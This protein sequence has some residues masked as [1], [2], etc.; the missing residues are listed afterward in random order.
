MTTDFPV[1]ARVS[2]RITRVLPSGLLGVVEGGVRAM[3]RNRE[4]AWKRTRSPRDY[5]GEVHP[6]IVIGFNPAY[7]ELEVSL[8]F[9]ERDPWRE[10][11]EKYRPQTVVQ[12]RV[13]GLIETAAFVELEPGVEGFLPAGELP[14]KEAEDITE[15]LWVDDHVLAAVTDVD[16][17][18]RRIRLSVNTLLERRDAQFQRRIWAAARATE[19]A[20]TLGE[21]LPRDVRLR[22]LQVGYAPEPA[23]SSLSP[24]RV[25]VVED[26]EAYAAGLETWL[27]K[28]GCQVSLAPN[29]ETALDLIRMQS[30]GFHLV[31][32]DW[33]LPG[34]KG[35]E[36]VRQLQREGCPSRAVVIL[37]PAPLGERPEV[38]ENLR[39]TGVDVFSKS[40][41]EG[42]QTGLV[43][44]LD[45]L[46]RRGPRHR[47]LRRYWSVP[48]A[49]LLGSGGQRRPEQP[50]SQAQTHDATRAIL[51]R[52][53]AD[54]HA[55]TVAL[56]SLVPGRRRF[57]VECSV[58][59][60]IPLDG[61]PPDLIYSPLGTVVCERQEVAEAV[62]ADS[63]RF[64]RLLD[65]L[66][67]QGFL[68][69][70]L[71][72]TGG[73]ARGLILLKRVG[74]FRGAD[75]VQARLY[76]TLIA[77]VLQQE[78][79]LGSLKPWQ[80]QSA[81][82]QLVASAIHE[83]SNKL[84]AIERQV[85]ALRENVGV[86]AARP[87]MA[88]DV[89]F[90]REMERAV[91]TIARVLR[92]T[93]RLRDQYLRLTASDDLHST[94]LEDLVRDAVCL[95]RPQAQSQDILIETR[96]A[97]D[98]PPVQAPPGSFTQILLNLL[99]NAI[100]QMAQLGRRGCIVV[101]VSCVEDAPLPIQVRVADE[102][103]GVHVQLWERIFD[104]GFTTKRAGGAGLGLTISRQIAE[105]LGG[106]LR[107]EESN[108]LWGTTFLLEL[109]GGAK[110]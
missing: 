39:E 53:A 22:L 96:V 86:L 82:G 67:F 20:M 79:L 12:G 101:D 71:P 104:F 106:R 14:R 65:I 11:A 6:G 75:R 3:V 23:A 105:S 38:L 100:Q 98:L 18:R 42:L 5:V 69:I 44:V 41:G 58:G 51:E 62:V 26:D 34:M 63:T 99:L 95:V 64:K 31:V 97:P 49:P 94:T 2:V 32:V 93:G 87:D 35:H 90:L 110:G 1:N 107:V 17:A 25:L 55:T 84:G 88:E 37:E 103:P 60:P 81:A 43:A 102:G 7:Q 68:G 10:V 48:V 59:E 33:N 85:D 52:V 21:I 28:N 56:V 77:G 46:R 76:S 9:A 66:P 50:V 83:I 13:V 8:R 47:T 74:G 15:C 78:Q 36:V 80:A 61:A 92:D 89:T 45:E 4:I 30:D 109:P 73:A 72:K 108:M 29:G 24:L 91:E 16:I 19:S 57:H 70:P 54:T 40:D 27:R